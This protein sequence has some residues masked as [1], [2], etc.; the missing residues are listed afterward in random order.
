MQNGFGFK[1]RTTLSFWQM[2][3]QNLLIENNV[4]LKVYGL[5][6][7]SRP[8]IVVWQ[9]YFVVVSLLFIEFGDLVFVE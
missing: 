6:K 4:S 5:I 7:K 2:T 9:F 3:H 1:S 8:I